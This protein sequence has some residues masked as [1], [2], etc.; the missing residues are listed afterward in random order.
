MADWVFLGL[1]GHCLQF[2]D[3]DLGVELAGDLLEESVDRLRDFLILW[4]LEE[5]SQGPG[6]VEPFGVDLNLLAVVSRDDVIHGPDIAAGIDPD[7]LA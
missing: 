7:S 4:L 6:P 2:V 3:Q 1:F 5:L